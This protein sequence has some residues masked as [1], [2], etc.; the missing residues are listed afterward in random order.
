MASTTSPTVRS[1][2]CPADLGRG[3]KPAWIVPTPSIA[4]PRASRPRSALSTSSAQTPTTAGLV[5][6]REAVTAIPFKAVPTTT[7]TVSGIQGPS[8][9]ATF[10][11]STAEPPIHQRPKQGG[12]P[13]ATLTAAGRASWS[14]PAGSWTGRR[15]ASTVIH[16]DGWRWSIKATAAAIPYGASRPLDGTAR[17]RLS[18]DPPEFLRLCRPP[19]HALPSVP[20]T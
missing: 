12:H 17:R 11:S 15:Q 13:D 19:A 10:A 14:F 8:F 6:L 3:R 4:I 9:A 18:T 5:I 20:V 16:G 1:G 2:P 7:P